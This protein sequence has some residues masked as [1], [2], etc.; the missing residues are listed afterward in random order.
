MS[1]GLG[2]DTPWWLQHASSVVVILLVTSQTG[3]MKRV[4]ASY[5]ENKRVETFHVEDEK[6]VRTQ[7]T[8]MPLVHSAA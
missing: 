4:M 3:H 7:I 5:H 1:G 8:P 2:S 6:G